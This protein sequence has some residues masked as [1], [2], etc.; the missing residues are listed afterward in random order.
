MIASH[1]PRQFR[2]Y[3]LENKVMLYEKDLIE[4]GVTIAPDGLPYFHKEPLFNIAIMWFSG[5]KAS[6]GKKVYEGDICEMAVLNE[7]GSATKHTAIMQYHKPANQFILQMPAEK[8][9]QVFN[10][11]DVKIIGNEFDNPDL[12]QLVTTKKFNG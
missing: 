12:I 1:F 6:D 2:A 3:D 8:G 7:F 4:K 5:Q 10:V 11:V 9:N